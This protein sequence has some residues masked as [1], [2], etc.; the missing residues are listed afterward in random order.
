MLKVNELTKN[1]LNQT[2]NLNTNMTN[3]IIVGSTQDV[4]RIKPIK[5]EK[6]LHASGWVEAGIGPG[7]FKFVELI[8]KDYRDVG[9]LMFAYNDPTKRNE[10]V[11]YKGKFN[12]GTV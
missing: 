3:V 1:K 6:Y 5:F 11:F 9:D 7:D 12:S 2:N 10:G 8:V 4:E